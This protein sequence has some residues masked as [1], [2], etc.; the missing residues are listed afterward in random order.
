[1]GR[2]TATRDRLGPHELIVLSDEDRGLRVRIARR[3]ATVLGLAIPVQGALRELIDGYRD[4]AEFDARPSS[5]FAVMA[6][7]ANRIAN[8]R[9]RFD[10]RELDLQPGAAE[11]ERAIRHGFL[12]GVDFAIGELRAGDDQASAVFASQA[13]RPETHPGYPFAIDFEL[14]YTVSAAGLGLE[15]VMRNAG[16]TAAPCFFG[17]HPYFRVA[18]GAIDGW[19][20]HIPARSLVRTDA[21]AIPLPGAAAYAPVGAEPALDFSTPRAIGAVKLDLA[22]ADLQADADGR[23]RTRLRDPHGGLALAIW[24]E[25]GVML[26]FTADTVARDPRGAVALEPMESMADAFNRPDCAAAIRLEPGAE[27]HFRC[28]VEIE[29]G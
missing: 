12:R 26:A 10:G 27:R 29:L 4:Q 8:A 24:Q 11:D 14:R 25:R 23:I 20:L 9:Y 5:R 3:G 15:A 2:Y 21:A 28:G 17:W 22:Y 18:G 1:M 6:P 19:Q 13:I 7:F 16:D